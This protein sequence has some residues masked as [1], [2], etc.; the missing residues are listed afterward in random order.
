MLARLKRMAAWGCLVMAGGVVSGL[1]EGPETAA[2]GNRKLGVGVNLGNAFE[3]PAE[4]AWGVRLAAEDFDRIAKA[5]FDSVRIPVRWSAHAG[6]APPYTIDPAFFARVDWAIDQ[7]LSRGLAVV[8]NQHHFNELY[9]DP[10]GQRDRFIALWRQIAQHYRDRPPALFFEILNE[11]HD[12]LDR[13]QWNQLLADTVPVIRASNPTRILVVG[14]AGWN[15]YSELPHLHLPEGDDRI[16]ATFHYYLPFPFTHQGA[17][18]AGEHSRQWLGTRWTGSDSE[19][20]AV[21]HHLDAAAAWARNHNVPLFLGEFGA[22]EKADIASRAAW[23]RF[24]REEARRRGI[25]VAYWEY[26]AGF[27][28]YDPAARQWRPQLLDALLPAAR[29]GN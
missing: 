23:T 26:C 25:S 21:I 22:Y 28:V 6:D 29:S 5:G 7:A 12:R 1:A 20:Q 13:Q 27:G 14:P 19:K 15:A 4:G 3:A 8:L 18:W 16:I 10:A 2:D 24:V 17:S 11:P 9:A